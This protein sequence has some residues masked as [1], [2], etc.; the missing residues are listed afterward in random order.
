MF[1]RLR[2]APKA[3]SQFGPGSM[4]QAILAYV[5]LASHLAIEVFLRQGTPAG[6]LETTGSD[7]GSAMLY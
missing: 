6:S 2:D 5:L 3:T 4:I 1:A 7:K